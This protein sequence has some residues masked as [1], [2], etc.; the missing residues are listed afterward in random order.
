MSLRAGFWKKEVFASLSPGSEERFFDELG[1]LSLFHAATLDRSDLRTGDRVVEGVGT[2]GGSLVVGD[3]GEGTGGSALETRWSSV[4]A[5]VGRAGGAIVD[6]GTAAALARL[7]V[8]GVR[9]AVGSI[10]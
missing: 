5:D 4:A 3:R 10:S 8:R 6:A 2:R 1:D 9:A 7:E